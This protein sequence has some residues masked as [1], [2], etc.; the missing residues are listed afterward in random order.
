[1]TDKKKKLVIVESPAKCKKIESILG[2]DYIC[3]ASYG[4]IM[5]LKNVKIDEDFKPIFEMDHSLPIKINN[6]KELIK[7]SKECSEV[8]IASDLDR[9]GEAIG[10]DLIEVLKL[11]PKK[12]KRI[13]FNEITKSSILNAI[14]N[15]RTIDIDLYHA[16]LARVILDHIIG[17]KLSPILW[18][19]IS[20]DLSAGRVQ[21]PGLKLLCDREHKIANFDSESFYKIIAD[22]ELEDNTIKAV[23]SDNIIKKEDCLKF[24]NLCKDSIFKIDSIKS[25]ESNRSPPQPFITSTLQQE[26]SK[27]YGISPKMCMQCA[28]KLYESGL[29]TY[30]RTDSVQLSEKAMNDIKDY[31]IDKYSDKYYQKREFKNKSENSQEAH[32]AIRP[33]DISKDNVNNI[34]DDNYTQKLYSL[35]WKR[36]V[37]S[38]M[39]PLKVNVNKIVINIS[40]TDKYQFIST[41]NRI[42]FDGYTKVYK[43]EDS[44]IDTEQ[45]LL[46]LKSLD[47][48]QILS[49]NQIIAKQ[50]Y[51]RPP[52]R[53]SEADLIKELEKKGIGRPSTY[54]GII[55]KIVTIRKYAEKKNDN[56]KTIAIDNLILDKNK[57]INEGH[58]DKVYDAF[59]GRLVVTDIGKTV[60]EFLNKHFNSTINYS[61]TSEMEKKLD[62][63]AEGKE[64]W[65]HTL[66][67]FYD[68]FSPT[69]TQL[70]EKKID[71]NDEDLKRRYLG[72]VNNQKIYVTFTK[73]GL[74]VAEEDTT[75]KKKYSKF[76]MVPSEYSY[77]DITLEQAKSLLIYPLVLGSYKGKD[78]VVNK[79]KYGTYFTYNGKNNSI[80]TMENITLENAIEII[81]KKETETQNDIIK[82]FSKNI[83][84]K[85]GKIVNDKQLSSYLQV[86]QG[87][88]TIFIPIPK[89]IDEQ[90]ISLEKVNELIDNYKKPK[91]MTKKK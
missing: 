15:P 88:N 50:D 16:Q 25:S 79:G 56:G 73:F 33:V 12:T 7:K 11:D 77:N 45:N 47:I 87:K 3:K 65:R 2:K 21:S 34:I 70:N 84:L 42:I 74:T 6:T 9:E 24:L 8:I 51:T 67:D 36:S 81:E 72:E 66:H 69:V 85:K 83:T 75:K 13:V 54:S 28:Q 49:Y 86:K 10:Y 35:I 4:H 89:D 60:N 30:M 23:L 82:E 80:K 17:Y 41:I 14:N 55:D 64:D 18:K 39:K 63:I 48:N 37:S 29:I 78:I 58:E 32:E 71:T 20:K 61:F 53:L 27:V 59:K 91:K 26:A 52:P 5:K 22:F 68:I 62:L 38:Q 90:S 31:V 1:M 43:N 46:D 44:D 76:A 40:K 19:Y 57:K